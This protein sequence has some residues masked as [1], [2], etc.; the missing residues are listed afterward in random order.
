[1]LTPLLVA[2]EERI[3]TANG[4]TETLLLQTILDQGPAQM[5]DKTGLARGH[6]GDASLGENSSGNT[7]P[8]NMASVEVDEAR[9]EGI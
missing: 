9:A 3:C 5:D 6:S 2:N 4:Q 8:E 7:F 1:L